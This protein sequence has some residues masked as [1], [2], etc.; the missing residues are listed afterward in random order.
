MNVDK[1]RLRTCKLYAC[2]INVLSRNTRKIEFGNT[3][4]ILHFTPKQHS[5]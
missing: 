1:K 5:T 4:Y 3:F 2:S